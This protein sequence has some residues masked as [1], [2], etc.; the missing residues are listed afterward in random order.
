MPALLEHL[1]HIEADGNA[2][3]GIASVVQIIAAIV[4]VHVYVIV[5]VP[6]V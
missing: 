4:V 6:I 3:S 1:V 5:V 2:I